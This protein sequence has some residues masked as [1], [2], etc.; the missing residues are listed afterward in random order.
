MRTQAGRPTTETLC[1][2]G[3]LEL[4]ELI[5]CHHFHPIYTRKQHCERTMVDNLPPKVVDDILSNSHPSAMNALARASLTARNIR[6]TQTLPPLRPT[7]RIQQA[8]QPLPEPEP[9]GRAGEQA[10]ADP[11][12]A[13]SC[14][15]WPGA[16][17][18]GHVYAT[19]RRVGA[20]RGRAGGLR[21]AAVHQFLAENYDNRYSKATGEPVEV[22]YWFEEGDVSREFVVETAGEDSYSDDGHQPVFQW[23][24]VMIHVVPNTSA[25]GREWTGPLGVNDPELTT[26]QPGVNPEVRGSLL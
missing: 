16:V 21:G 3:L 24:M 8:R 11:K 13:G 18:A 22:Y 14:A 6:P 17:A 9:D 20:L 10:R 5:S 23:V 2:H 26:R 7:A 19:G 4:R 1:T 15:G 12:S 25:D